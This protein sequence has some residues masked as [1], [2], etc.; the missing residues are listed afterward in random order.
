MSSESPE[1]FAPSAPAGIPETPP[2]MQ[3]AP[4]SRARLVVV[5]AAQVLYA[6][7]CVVGI[8]IVNNQVSLA[9]RILQGD[10]IGADQANASDNSVG[11][12]TLVLI[13]AF[14]FL[15]VALA[16][17]E[18]NLKRALG[19]ERVKALSRRFGLRYVWL[20]WGLLWAVGSVASAGSPTDPQSIVSADHRTMF[21][22][23]A[24]AVLL[25]VISALTVLTMKGAQQEL[26]RIPAPQPFAPLSY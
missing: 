24:R 9:N 19:K 16:L 10:T 21:L 3:L 25:L 12:I 8:V 4:L 26:D 22:L 15:L 14:V 13:A 11:A 18:R 7:V 23:G 5:V 2:A 6:I 1:P 17:W 20:I